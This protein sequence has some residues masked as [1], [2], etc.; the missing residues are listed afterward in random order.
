MAVKKLAHL[1]ITLGYPDGTFKPN[2][3]L[4]R[5]HISAFI[6]RAMNPAFRPVPKRKVYL[7]L[8]TK[9]IMLNNITTFMSKGEVVSILGKPKKEYL[10]IDLNQELVQEYPGMSIYYSGEIVDSII[11]EVSEKEFFNEILPDFAGRKFTDREGRY[12]LYSQKTGNTALY[13]YENG[14][15]V[16]Y[17]SSDYHFNKLVESGEYGE[18]VEIK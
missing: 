12:L 4:T 15:T 8:V 14:K 3:H 18:Y 1:N 13:K 2:Q 16:M 11:A 10:D 9:R 5:A 6:A 17:L 7:D